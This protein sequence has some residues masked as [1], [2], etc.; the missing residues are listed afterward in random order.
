MIKGVNQLLGQVKE[1]NFYAELKYPI[2]EE[3][4][5]GFIET[6]FRKKSKHVP[7]SYILQNVV[8]LKY[9]Y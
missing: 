9:G 5:V 8:Y 3:S 6:R 4:K 1:S 2:F 7:D